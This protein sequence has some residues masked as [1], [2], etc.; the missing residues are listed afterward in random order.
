MLS[1]RVLPVCLIAG[2]L[3]VGVDTTPAGIQCFGQEPSA[4]SMV[5]PSPNRVPMYGRAAGGASL[6][7]RQVASGPSMG[8]EYGLVEEPAGTSTSILPP[9]TAADSDSAL[10]FSQ[11]WGWEM[12]PNGLMYPSYLAGGREPRF[13]SQWVYLRDRGW[14]WDT[15]LGARVGLLRHGT[16]DDP[17]PEGWQFDMEGAIFPRLDLEARRELVASD[18]RAGGGWTFRRGVWEGKF[19]YYHISAHL[20]DE[21]RFTHPEVER[22][23]YVRDT[24][25]LG[26]ALRP[27]RDLRLYSEVGYAVYTDGGAE[28]WEFQF[29]VEYSPVEP[30]GARGAPFVATNAHLRQDNNFSGNIALQAGWQ[31]RG[32]SGHLFRVGAHYFNG[33]SDQ[34]QFFASAE[35]QI[36]V[37]M[38]YDF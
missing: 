11:T 16:L 14:V 36:G 20:G 17:W 37:G 30:T 29:G 21:F 10:G 7:G 33:M 18:Y 2:W 35:D 9:H 24:L 38:W 1:R 13:A 32:Y 4:S 27:W 28:P 26:F 3:W 8:G 12:L 22:I 15:T 34:Y 31:W 23:N 25:V 6:P 19:S 5:A